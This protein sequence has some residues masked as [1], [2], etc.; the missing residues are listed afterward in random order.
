VRRITKRLGVALGATLACGF[1]CAPATLA[2]QMAVALPP[3]CGSPVSDATAENTWGSLQSAIES[4]TSTTPETFYLT[5]TQITD[6]TS[7]GLQVQPGA[8]VTLD[9]DGCDLSIT[10]PGPFNA[11]INVPSGSSL[12][13]ED[14][15]SSVLA[16]QGTLTATGGT[17]STSGNL[18]GG[19]GAGIGGTAISDPDRRQR[20]QGHRCRTLCRAG[21]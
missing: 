19:G 17:T 11:A 20:S 3:T 7:G 1:L 2:I 16:D 15:S 21:A 10:N 4:D 8:N 13:I 5:S 12:T 6:T 14:T 18:L 9:L